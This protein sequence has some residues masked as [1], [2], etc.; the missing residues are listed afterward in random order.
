MKKREILPSNFLKS[1]LLVGFLMGATA[2][3]ASDTSALEFYA[4]YQDANG[5]TISIE[6]S[7]LELPDNVEFFGNRSGDGEGL[8]VISPPAIDESCLADIWAGEHPQAEYPILEFKFTESC[9]EEFTKFTGDNIGRQMAVIL[10]G[11]LFTAPRING[12]INADGMF[13]EGGFESMAEVEAL[14]ASF[15][16]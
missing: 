10:N 11:E 1:T 5:E 15:K 2:C 12:A 6:D 8:F 9:A 4:V 16:N 14:A 3:S 7:S 13:I